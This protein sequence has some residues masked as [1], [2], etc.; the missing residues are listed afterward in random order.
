M[1]PNSDWRG[2][3]P[4]RESSR[5]SR[6]QPEWKSSGVAVTGGRSGRVNK[7]KLVGAILTL[8]CLI[9]LGVWIWSLKHTH[10]T[11]VVVANLLKDNTNFEPQRGFKRPLEVKTRLD[12]LSVLEA[13]GRD[14]ASQVDK[15]EKLNVVV[16][17]LQSQLIPIATEDG[18]PDF[19]CIAPGTTP[20]LTGERETLNHWLKELYAICDSGK[21]VLLMLDCHTSRVDWRAGVSSVDLNEFFTRYFADAKPRKRPGSFTIVCSDSAC[22]GESGVA[23]LGGLTRLSYAFHKAINETPAASHGEISIR[24]FLK[25]LKDD[26]GGVRAPGIGFSSPRLL[27]FSKDSSQQPVTSPEQIPD[28]VLFRNVK[29]DTAAIKPSNS[30]PK[31]LTTSLN[32][33]KKMEE[34]RIEELWPERWNAISEQLVWAERAYFQGRN[35]DAKGLLDQSESQLKQLASSLDTAGTEETA[36]AFSELSSLLDTAYKEFVE[37]NDA[38]RTSRHL[39]LR[40]SFENAVRDSEQHK[41]L[42]LLYSLMRDLHQELLEA[43]DK[44]FSQQS[45]DWLDDGGLKKLEER[46][47]TISKFVEEYGHATRTA[48]EALKLLPSTVFWCAQRSTLPTWSVSESEWLPHLEEICRPPKSLEQVN[49]KVQELDRVPQGI[50]KRESNARA[51]RVSAIGSLHY[52]VGLLRQLQSIWKRPDDNVGIAALEMNSLPELTK[53]LSGWRLKTSEQLESLPNSLKKSIATS[54]QDE[55]GENLSQASE[56]SAQ[57]AFLYDSLTLTFLTATDRRLIHEKLEKIRTQASGFAPETPQDESTNRRGILVELRWAA[58]LSTL[59]AGGQSEQMPPIVDTV[60]K[61]DLSQQDVANAS[62]HLRKLWKQANDETKKAYDSV[63]PDAFQRAVRSSLQCRL[64][65]RFDLM[66]QQSESLVKR[67]ATLNELESRLLHADLIAQSGWFSNKVKWFAENSRRNL[68]QFNRLSKE[69]NLKL[70][71]TYLDRAQ[72][73]ENQL[74]SEYSIKPTQRSQT[75]RIGRQGQESDQFQL[76]IAATLPDG[77]KGLAVVQFE[78]KK[79]S[80]S[81]AGLFR[82][83]NDDEPLTIDLKPEGTKTLTVTREGESAETACE[84]DVPVPLFFR[85]QQ[86]IQGPPLKINACAPIQYTRT[87]V[88]RAQNAKITVVGRDPHPLVFILDWSDSMKND[89]ADGTTRYKAASEALLQLANTGN[90]EQSHSK[91]FLRV[92]GHRTSVTDRAEIV[93]NEQYPLLFNQ[94]PGF[95]APGGNDDSH[96]EFGGH[97]DRD[98]A[99]FTKVIENLEK[100]TTTGTGITPLFLSLIRALD[101]D[102]GGGP[103]TIVAITDGEPTDDG[104]PNDRD[105]K[106][107]EKGPNDRRRQLLDA[108][109]KNDKARIRI[110][111]FDLTD[112]QLTPLR[113]T[114]EESEE[115]LK[116]RDRIKLISADDQEQLSREISDGLSPRPYIARELQK[117]DL[118]PVPLGQGVNVDPGTWNVRLENSSIADSEIAYPLHRGDSLK[119]NYEFGRRRFSIRGRTAEASFTH[120]VNPDDPRSPRRVTGKAELAG[121]QVNVTLWLEHDDRTKFVEQPEEIDIQVAAEGIEGQSVDLKSIRQLYDSSEGVPGWRSECTGWP[122]GAA[123]KVNVAWKM[124]RTSPDD[125]WPCDDD[126]LRRGNFE[127]A[128]GLE[129]QNLPKCS[130]WCK[131]FLNDSRKY[132]EVRVDP[133]PGIPISDSNPVNRL[134]VELGKRNTVGEKGT[135]TPWELR[136]EVIRIDESVIFRFY[137]DDDNLLTAD[138]VRNG[139]ELGF[140]SLKSRRENAVE[141]NDLVIDVK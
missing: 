37:T 107:V 104:L 62:E 22:H 32:I 74:T 97:L 83:W 16:V 119:L 15:F 57:H 47:Q 128:K 17:L 53:N 111:A 3:S 65:T 138:S 18:K 5:P 86:W 114:F 51:T 63:E 134:R 7:P 123:A 27:M 44:S 120:D 84:H 88:P 139:A 31:L 2:N 69:K 48:D 94:E 115:F 12:G 64:L 23:N 30:D 132:F 38:A 14:V 21:N 25:H 72:Q 89:T 126:F 34:Q 137:A 35:S 133:K 112:D 87:L 136:T 24:E 36:A 105:G 85:G 96:R 61:S 20:D 106:N 49:V 60:L 110:V 81:S 78:S 109:S 93:A 33:W 108:L 141:A 54:V 71:S 95:K 99:E 118:P 56:L 68:D 103:G 113:K 59:V 127:N 91:V 41:C 140:T 98:R 1:T 79:S 10:H 13:S 80:A 9:V 75:I 92:F 70:S 45:S 73:I 90:L 129:G 40:R 131:D 39:E 58:A 66:G 29:K 26:F 101:T 50:G 125:V 135:F 4:R 52:T 42:P 116:F 82:F 43:E 6:P 28:Y 76:D 117:G 55:V 124:E 121:P 67:V 130:V 19:A 77:V 8:V 100:L 122:E 46:V 11:L 102:L